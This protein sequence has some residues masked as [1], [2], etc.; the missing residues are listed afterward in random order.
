VGILGIIHAKYSSFIPAQDPHPIPFGIKKH[1][2]TS[3]SA[4]EHIKSVVIK[5]LC[6]VTGINNKLERNKPSCDVEDAKRGKRFG[7]FSM[8]KVIDFNENDGTHEECRLSKSSR[9]S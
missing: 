5:V 7:G 9:P 2:I 3:V 1:I 6:E 8:G 4:S